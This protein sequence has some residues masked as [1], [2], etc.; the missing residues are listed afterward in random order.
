MSFEELVKMYLEKW[1]I[2]DAEKKATGKISRKTRKELERL[3]EE[4]DK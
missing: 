2:A 3:A 1:K 4:L